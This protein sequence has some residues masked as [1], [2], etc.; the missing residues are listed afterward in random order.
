MAQIIYYLQP[1]P[2]GAVPPYYFDAAATIGYRRDGPRALVATTL[3]DPFTLVLDLKYG[4]VVELRALTTIVTPPPPPDPGIVWE[5]PSAVQ[6]IINAANTAKQASVTITGRNIA[7]TDAQNANMSTVLSIPNTGTKVIF[8][9]CRVKGAGPLFGTFRMRLGLYN[10]QLT[11]LPPTKDNRSAAYAVNGDEVLWLEVIGCDFLAAGSGI[12]IHGNSNTF[13]FQGNPAAGDHV[14]IQRNRVRNVDGRIWSASLGRY[15]RSNWGSTH[16]KNSL[17]VA[18]N[19]IYGWNVANFVRVNQCPGVPIDISDNQVF[20]DLGQSRHEDLITFQNGSGGSAAYPA[21]VRRNLLQSTGGYDWNYQDGVST[22]YNPSNQITLNADGYQATG[23]TSCT[24]TC[25]LV[26][27]NNRT[28]TNDTLA[29]NTSYVTVEQ[30][31]CYGPRGYVTQ[32]AGHHNTIINNFVFVTAKHLNG[33]TYSPTFGAAYQVSDYHNGQTVGGQVIWGFNTW[34]NNSYYSLTSGSATTFDPISA[35]AV[36]NGGQSTGNMKYLRDAD[37]TGQ[38]VVD[39][40]NAL[41]ASRGTTVGST[42]AV[43]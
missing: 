20:N 14:L 28:G 7:A 8:Q 16:N 30:N 43:P 34:S 3:T 27:D 17:R 38:S 36:K 13:V 33:V 19:G 41:M 35:D 12:Y 11:V 4:R 22:T 2:A 21:T 32:Q 29:T 6:T 10:C 26:G 40:H 39:L 24:S 9:D 1:A 42:L 37:P 15:I 31:Y 25:I 23:E 5:D 18:N